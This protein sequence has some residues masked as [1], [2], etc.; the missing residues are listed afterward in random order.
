MRTLLALMLFATPVV[1]GDFENAQAA[2]KTG[3]IGKALQLWRP[4][5]EQGDLKAQITLGA[6]YTTDEGVTKVLEFSQPHT[7]SHKEPR[8]LSLRQIG[9]SAG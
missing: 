9:N 1:A 6:L 7:Q 5:A 3:D 8:V 4:L 2:A